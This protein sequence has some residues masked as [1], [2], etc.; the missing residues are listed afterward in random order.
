MSICFLF[1]EAG[2]C[3][4][5]KADKVIRF[6]QIVPSAPD[7][8]CNKGE[9]YLLDHYKVLLTK[10]SSLHSSPHLTWVDGGSNVST[11]LDGNGSSGISQFFKVFFQIGLLSLFYVMLKRTEQIFKS[12]FRGLVFFYIEYVF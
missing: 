6:S 2:S 12:P 11:M 3:C 5:L 10:G 8:A 7:P 1:E 4:L 9:I